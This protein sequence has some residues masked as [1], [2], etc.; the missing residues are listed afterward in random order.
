MTEHKLDRGGAAAAVS[1]FTFWGL[2][3]VY[4]KGLQTVGAWEVLAHRIIWAVPTLLFFLAIRE[5]KNI[6]QKLRMAKSDIAWLTLTG[7][8]VAANWLI[9][10]WAVAH[11][12]V[13]DTSLGYFAT[14]I[15]NVVLGCVFL[16][17]RLPV[18][19]TVGVMIAAVGTL[20]LAWFLGRPPW[21]S[22][23]LAL[24]FGF[25]GLMR[26]RLTVQPMPGLL[27]ESS[28]MFLPALVYLLWLSTQTSQAF[29][30]SGAGVDL[31]LIF[32]GLTT[33][34]PLIWFNMA[35]QKLPLSI[36]GCFQ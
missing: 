1:A 28:L 26:K 10:V 5:R 29:L 4:Y 21:I 20:Y 19:Q 17:E 3:P 2:V 30:H 27:W 34:L 22:I 33:V 18:L 16:K 23:S 11:D 36:L 7:V 31:L 25:Y 12:H 15:V 13:L 24:T 6:L 14:P 9:F 8:T 32:S 35:A